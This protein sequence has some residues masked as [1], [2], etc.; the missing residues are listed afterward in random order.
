MS[1]GII[2]AKFRFTL[3][4][5][6]VGDIIIPISSFVAN[7]RN[8]QDSYLQVSIPDY[9]TYIAACHARLNGGKLKI[10]KCIND[11][12]YEEI[13]L[14]DV[15]NLTEDIGAKNKSITMTGHS[16][17]NNDDPQTVTLVAVES[18]KSSPLVSIQC[19]VINTINPG[20]TA[21]YDEYSFVPTLVSVVANETNSYM[22]VEQ[23]KIVP[24]MGIYYPAVSADDYFW[25]GTSFY[26][27]Q[28]YLKLGKPTAEA[29]H[30]G[31]CF[32]NILIPQAATITSAF[33]TLVGEDT[34]YTP[35]N[36]T[37]YGN[38]VDNASPPAN[39]AAADALTLTSA[40]KSWSNLPSFTPGV[41]ILTPDISDII[42]EII[43]REGWA[44]GNAL[45]LLL[46]DN[47]SGDN[48]L[49]SARSIEW[50]DP[51]GIYKPELQIIWET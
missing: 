46:K 48:T 16:I 27:D 4:H 23:T 11:G 29:H 9:D 7:L 12:S 40:S 21:I 44:P 1:V 2:D 15:E 42:Q 18:V 14:I 35:V 17:F 33:I 47:T 10:E 26:N 36:V 20:D 43:D 39:A 37:I 32:K 45:Q 22:K 19:S 25:H 38:D 31:I 13:C 50:G 6:G 34:D 49:R 30:M 28:I 51:A 41:K 8:C 5:S 3:I 24:F